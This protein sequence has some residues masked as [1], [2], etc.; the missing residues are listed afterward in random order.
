MQG[1][2]LFTFLSLFAFFQ[3]GSPQ[4]LN[5]GVFEATLAVLFRYQSLR[6]TYPA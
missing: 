6:F 2:I 4:E 1:G 5:K 3:A